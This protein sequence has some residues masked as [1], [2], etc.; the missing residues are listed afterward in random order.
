[1]GA[2]QPRVFAQ[3]LLRDP[4]LVGAQWL[5]DGAATGPAA[6]PSTGLKQSQQ[7]RRAPRGAFYGA[8]ATILLALRLQ[9]GRK[10][11]GEMSMGS[12]CNLK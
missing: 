8:A 6:Q 3:I 5:C 2:L 12:N 4:E 11:G 10:R 1:M 7:R 9:I